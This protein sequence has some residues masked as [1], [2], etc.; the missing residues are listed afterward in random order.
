M[1]LIFS[2]DR[3]KPGLTNL[4]GLVQFLLRRRCDAMRWPSEGLSLDGEPWP[5]STGLVAH[6]VSCDAA[7]VLLEMKKKKK[8]ENFIFKTVFTVYLQSLSIF[9]QNLRHEVKVLSGG[10]RR[11]LPDLTQTCARNDTSPYVVCLLLIS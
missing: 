8:R 4:L 9:L 11:I 10:S 2:S 3:P 1:S 5:K 7:A 6:L